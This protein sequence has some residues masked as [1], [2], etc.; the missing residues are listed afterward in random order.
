M[1]SLETDIFGSGNV[2]KSMVF[3]PG[4]AYESWTDILAGDKFRYK[5][6]GLLVN[7][8]K[9]YH[10]IYHIKANV[11]RAKFYGFWKRHIDDNNVGNI[12]D[13]EH[14]ARKRRALSSVMSEQTVRSAEKLVIKHVN[15]WCDVLLHDSNGEWS[16]PINFSDSVG[17]L[18]FDIVG[19]LLYGRSLDTK[20]AGENPLKELPRLIES[21]PRF[22][23]IVS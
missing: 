1:G 9:G 20:E 15:R 13:P 10:D 19:D 14:H 12:M 18:T 17:R 8:P 22:M 6:N 16:P 5:P 23:Y 21:L 3:D 7:S 2:I 11:K 4:L